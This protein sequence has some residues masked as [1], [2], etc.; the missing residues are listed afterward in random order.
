MSQEMSELAAYF[1]EHIFLAYDRYE[2]AKN[3]HTMGNN[4][5][6]REAIDAAVAL[7]HLREHIPQSLRKSRL[8]LAVVCPDY[9]LLGDIVNASKH[10]VITRGTPQVTRL[11]AIQEILV[12]TRFSDQD[13]EYANDE[14]IVE[15]ELIDGSKRDVYE[16]L[17]NVVN[18]WFDELHQIGA[19][20]RR[21]PMQLNRQ[22]LVTRENAHSVSLQITTGIRWKQSFRLQKY[23]YE[24]NKVES[25]DL[26]DA[27]NITFTVRKPP[28][29]EVELHDASGVKFTREIELTPEQAKDLK[30]I[31][32]PSQRDQYLL[33]IA[34]S[35][36]AVDQMIAEYQNP[37][38]KEQKP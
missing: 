20:E 14:K 26:S 34:I 13:G 23:N 19:I 21:Q 32:D 10:H 27:K 4:N 12:S 30:Q 35:Q 15:V 9:D 6:R 18:M 1:Y 36:G 37:K 24:S 5:D 7:Y 17:T 28:A 25:V 2:K 3:D 31:N 16:I 29:F 8:Q 33:K 22:S 11:D 38:N